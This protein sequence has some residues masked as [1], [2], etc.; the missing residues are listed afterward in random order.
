MEHGGS[1]HSAYTPTYLFLKNYVKLKLLKN[2]N[3]KLV[4]LA[5]LTWKCLMAGGHSEN[6]WVT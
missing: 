2:L 6:V 4:S 5:I 3:L 1:W